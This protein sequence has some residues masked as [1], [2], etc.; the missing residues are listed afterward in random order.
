MKCLGKQTADT[1]A[2]R[3]SSA[4]VK[5]ANLQTVSHFFRGRKVLSTSVNVN[6]S[7]SRR[8]L[9]NHPQR[10]VRLNWSLRKDYVLFLNKSINKI[11][12][13]LYRYQN[14]SCLTGYNTYQERVIITV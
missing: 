7:I 14:I 10:R 3:R 9:T 11:P 13:F 2:V 6:P 12:F 1:V 5:G 8:E 4:D